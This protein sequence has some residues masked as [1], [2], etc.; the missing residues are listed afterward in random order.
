MLSLYKRGRIFHVRGSVRGV[1]VRRSLDTQFREEAQQ[2]AMEIERELYSG[3]RV[4]LV[5]W[6][7]FAREFIAWAHPG[8]AASTEGKYQFVLDRF[9]DFL[10][11]TI[12]VQHI[13]PATVSKYL[14]QRERDRH[15]TRGGE[16]GP[17]GLKSDLR[18]L[19]RVFVYAV[20]SGYLE[21]NPVTHSR[22]GSRSRQTQPFSREEVEAMLRACDSGPGHGL[23]YALKPIILTFLH[24]GLRISDVIGLEKKAI[25]WAGKRLVIKTRKRGT[26]VSIPM[27]P[28]L[29][30]ALRAHLDRAPGQLIPLVFH[31]ARGQP[32][33]SLDA[34]LRRLWARAAV[35]GGHAHR[36]RDTFAVRLLER[37]ASLYDVAKL[38]GTTVAVCETHYAPYVKELQDRGQ[39]LIEMIPHA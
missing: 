28:D 7:D 29:A 25:D 4:R 6:K 8:I 37:G 15:P 34:Y 26:V 1:K 22:R 32:L 33:T 38:L 19:H 13:D 36:F 21:K 30:E 35:K 9:G 17:E 14:A 12:A 11:P 2:R 31:T 23:P 24:T 3:K 27:H 39:R 10:A 18:V 5:R 16:V 20:N